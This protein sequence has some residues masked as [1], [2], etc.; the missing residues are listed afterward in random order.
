MAR[1]PNPPPQPITCPHCKG[2]IHRYFNHAGDALITFINQIAVHSGHCEAE[3]LA[4]APSAKITGTAM[5]ADLQ[6]KWPT[7][8]RA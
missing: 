7:R 3:I 2:P 1:I 8:K 6:K 4:I 5:P